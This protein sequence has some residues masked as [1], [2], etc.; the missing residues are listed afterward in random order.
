M[1]TVRSAKLRRIICIAA[2]SLWITGI[3]DIAIAVDQPKPALSAVPKTC[4]AM[5]S[6]LAV[7]TTKAQAAAATCKSLKDE[8]AQLCVTDELTKMIAD[9]LA[10]M[11]E[12]QEA[13]NQTKDMGADDISE[14]LH[15]ADC[16]THERAEECRM[17]PPTP[18][19]RDLAAIYKIW[20]AAGGP[21]G[22]DVIDWILSVLSHNPNINPL[23]FDW[24][25]LFS[26]FSEI[27]A[28]RP[29]ETGQ[30]K[31]PGDPGY[32]PPDSP[33]PHQPQTIV[34][35]GNFRSGE[36]TYIRGTCWMAEKSGQDFMD[37]LRS[38]LSTCNNAGSLT[39]AS[40]I[41]QSELDNKCPA[42]KL[43]NPPIGSRSNDAESR[44]P[45]AGPNSRRDRRNKSQKV[46]LPV[47]K[48][49]TASPGVK[50]NNLDRF[51]LGPSFAPTE[52]SLPNQRA[53]GKPPQ[54][55][56]SKAKTTTSLAKPSSTD[57]KR[58]SV[59]PN[60]RILTP[61]EQIK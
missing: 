11:A 33:G 35:I 26:I 13:V 4:A 54:G 28:S 12:V 58:P 36:F 2:T 38:I 6:A 21:T 40:N 27:V 5:K 50:S 41:E 34:G 8:F 23:T 37:Y 42:N 9:Y 48:S 49:Q 17:G 39:R 60:A 18:Q 43:R 15:Y 14:R 53:A 57:S 51:G 3:A 44:A 61:T 45:D 19:E 46:G 47:D 20:L 1:T 10:A 25:D 56:S 30:V 7:T 29:Y 22:A 24:G 55:G 31:Q 59:D 16:G 52:S 32:I